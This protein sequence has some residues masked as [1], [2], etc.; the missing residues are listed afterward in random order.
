VDPPEARLL[1]AYDAGA[2]IAPLSDSAPLSMT[3]GYAIAA[4]IASL[5]Q[6]RGE[7]IAGRKIGFTN[8]RIWPLYGVDAPFW[9][10]MYDGTVHDIPS[11]GRI[12]L[13]ALPEL[14]IEPEIAF[15]FK[16]T[17]TPEM[18]IDAIAGC[19]DW[20][21][22]GVE[23]VMSLYPGWKI[24]A[25]DGVAG[26]GMHGACWLGDLRPAVEVLANG[27]EVLERLKLTLTGPGEQLSGTGADVLD[28]PL[29]ALRHL[30][31]EIPKMPG[32][33]PIQPGEVVTTGTLTDAR[34]IAKGQRWQTQIEGATLP[35]LDITFV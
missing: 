8:R 19:I 13:P 17:P 9:G 24:T 34:P 28:S 30:M 6:A 16:S 25:P 1:Q 33:G 5:R 20:V 18:D 7:K 32:A 15:G 22:H 27:A 11:D 26:M 35:G 10:W 4:E 12:P 23:L 2:Q 3:E 21:A 31:R 29:H 14:R